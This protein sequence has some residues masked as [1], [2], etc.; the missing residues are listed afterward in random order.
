M[1]SRFYQPGHSRHEVHHQSLGHSNQGKEPRTSPG[2]R[3]WRN[4]MHIYR[5]TKTEAGW[6]N[7]K[8]TLLLQLLLLL[9]LRLH[10]LSRPITSIR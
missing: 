6:E 4:T 2:S 8:K 1:Y 5:Y 7:A 3:V 10:C 9:P